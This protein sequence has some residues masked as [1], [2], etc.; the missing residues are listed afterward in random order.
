MLALPL[1]GVRLW[2]HDEALRDPVTLAD[3][4]IAD[5]YVPMGIIGTQRVSLVAGDGERKASI[6]LGPDTARIACG[7]LDAMADAI[8]AAFAMATA[9]RSAVTVDGLA[10]IRLQD[11]HGD[12]VRNV[13]ALATPTGCLFVSSDGIPFPAPNAFMPAYDGG[14]KIVTQVL[15]DIRIDR[16]VA[17]PAP[18][19]VTATDLGFTVTGPRIGWPG[20]LYGDGDGP[21]WTFGFGQ[22]VVDLCSRLVI[23]YAARPGEPLWKVDHLDGLSLDGLRRSVE[24]AFRYAPAPTLIRLDGVQAWRWD[25]WVNTVIAVHDGRAY[26]IQARPGFMGDASLSDLDFVLGGWSWDR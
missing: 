18:P 15:E 6:P 3:K 19:K 9:T 17:T 13:V 11:R 26:L 12:R 4:A 16:P 20:T 1:L 23:V 8:S 22:C 25:G 21:G 24:T 7:T 10:G 14:D 5:L 2:M